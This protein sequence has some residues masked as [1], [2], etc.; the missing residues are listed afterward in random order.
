MTTGRGAAIALP[1]AAGLLLAACGS[2][3]GTAST[4]DPTAGGS[5]QASS[6]ASSSGG[7]GVRVPA[8]SCDIKPGAGLL[9]NQTPLPGRI[10]ASIAEIES[11]TGL[12]VSQSVDISEV[13]GMTACR[14]Q[15]GNGQVNVTVLDDPSQAQAELARTRSQGLALA[16]RGCNGCTLSGFTAL[17]ELGP[18]GYT[19]TKDQNPVYGAIAGGI[20]FEV[21][22]IGLKAVRLER[23]ALVIAANL[24]G[25]ASS[26]LPALPM[27]TPSM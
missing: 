5:T 24:G 6:S 4:S 16:D 22:G 20:Y 11:A 25:G 15:V 19:A 2:G 14:Y 13:A 17:A 21:D 26:S 9:P 10:V 23:L 8:F 18:D 27:P 1:L 3:G 12:G 7:L